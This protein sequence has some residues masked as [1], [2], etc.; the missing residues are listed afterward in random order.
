M[1]DDEGH[2]RSGHDSTVATGAEQDAFDGNVGSGNRGL[3]RL[4]GELARGFHR[5]G[6]SIFGFHLVRRRRRSISTSSTF[7]EGVTRHFG[8]GSCTR[9]RQRLLRFFGGRAFFLNDHSFLG[10][11]GRL[12]PGQAG[13]GDGGGSH[14]Q[15]SFL[16]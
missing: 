12:G 6:C 4:I 3:N 8:L 5:G 10:S 16:H 2:G 1:L 11:L 9:S 13:H 15:Q 7:D 14:G